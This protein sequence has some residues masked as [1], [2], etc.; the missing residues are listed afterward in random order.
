[1]RRATTIDMTLLML[2]AAIWAGAFVAI[3]VA[4]PALGP[5]GVAAARAVIGFVVLLPFAL[6]V[7]LPSPP[8]ARTWLLLVAMAELNIAL[9]FF[10]IS[11]AE[12]TVEAGVASL[13]MGVGPLFAMVGAHY[14]NDDDRMSPRRALGVALGFIGIVIL[15]GA[16]AIGGLG[17]AALLPQGALIGASLCYVVSG[18]LVRKIELA[19]LPLAI[20]ALA[21]AAMTLVPILWIATEAGPSLDQRTLGAI[22]FLGIFPTGLAYILRFY[23]IKTVG[24]ATFAL[25]INLIPVFGVLLGILV[26]NERLTLNVA[27]ALALVLSGLFVARGR[28]NT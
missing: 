2:T 1:M 20:Y 10:L 27:I 22:L 24:Y 16:E 8:N 9:P 15:V 7:G 26:L 28:A 23:L 3:K 18:L 4:V 13:L 14:F 12:Q 25:S 6:F 11:W 17:A 5:V 21:I 19:A